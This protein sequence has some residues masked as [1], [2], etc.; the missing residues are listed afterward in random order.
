MVVK[1]WAPLS[2][3][4]CVHLFA[5]YISK[6]AYPDPGLMNFT[7]FLDFHLPQDNTTDNWSLHQN[8]YVSCCCTSTELQHVWL[9]AT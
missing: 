6:L 5:A 1:E 9:A 8:K 4:T 3:F 7:N 2:H